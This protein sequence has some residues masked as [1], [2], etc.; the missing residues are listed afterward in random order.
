MVGIVGLTMLVSLSL[1][2][3]IFELCRRASRETG[4]KEYAAVFGLK[5]RFR[6]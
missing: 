2:S 1:N 4:V 5:L 6:Q 3:A